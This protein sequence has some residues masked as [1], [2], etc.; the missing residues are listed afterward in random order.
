MRRWCYACSTLGAVL[1][2]A[3]LGGCG[4]GAPS[5]LAPKADVVALT[6]PL[7]I[8]PVRHLNRRRSWILPD[9]KKQWLIYA[10]DNSSGTIDIYNYRV[11]AGKLYGQITG[12]VSPY[13][14]CI[15]AAGDVYAVDSSTDE[16][17]EYAHGG[18]TPIATATDEYGSPLGCS[19]DPTNGNVAV[20]NF[21]GPSGGGAGGV[22]IFAGGLSGSQTYYTNTS[23]LYHLYPPGYDPHGN[24]F[25]QA[26]EYSGAVSFAELPAGHSTFALLTGLK[27]DFPGSVQWDGYYLAVTDQDY[28]YSATTAIYRVTVSG[29]AVTV[30]RTTHLTDDCYPHYNWMAEVQPFVSG[31]TRKLNAVVSGNLN[32]PTRYGFWNYTN[33][34]DPKRVIPAGIA[35]GVVYGQAVSPPSTAN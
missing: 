1:A 31:T 6:N 32:C 8:A 5:A 29:S 20:S 12:L 10:G 7:G 23:Y 18:I 13:G 9:A 28:Q 24:L 16:I 14:L 2:V 4:N 25:V 19:V 11:Q 21:S 30:V 22:D 26:T 27:I 3:L 15:D 17:Y 34:G 33:G 35:P